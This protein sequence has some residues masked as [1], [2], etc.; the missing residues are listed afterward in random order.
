MLATRIMYLV[1]GAM[2]VALPFVTLGSLEAEPS[3]LLTVLWIAPVA[4]GVWIAV[5]GWRLALQLGETSI[6]IVGLTT[7]REIPRA[8]VHSMSGLPMLP[9]LVWI[10]RRGRRRVAF[11]SALSSRSTALPVFRRHAAE[12][13]AAVMAWIAE[14]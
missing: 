4:I 1:I 8:S 9:G 11:L 5:S 2:Q 6:R 3:V 13:R 14:R 10:D 12:G 7:I